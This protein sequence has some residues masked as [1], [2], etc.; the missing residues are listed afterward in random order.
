MTLPPMVQ[1]NA[2]G[3]AASEADSRLHAFRRFTANG[4]QVRKMSSWPRSWA[5]FSLF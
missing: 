4:L 3:A 5:N 1:V 2:E